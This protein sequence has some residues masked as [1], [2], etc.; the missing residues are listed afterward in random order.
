MLTGVKWDDYCR[1]VNLHCICAV[2]SG[3]RKWNKENSLYHRHVIGRERWL[4][5]WLLSSGWSNVSRGTTRRAPK[6]GRIIDDEGKVHNLSHPRWSD[7]RSNL[8]TAF[9]RFEPAAVTCYADLLVVLLKSQLV[10][11]FT[12]GQRWSDHSLF[13]L[14]MY[15]DYILFRGQYNR[16]LIWWLRGSL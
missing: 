1:V 11:L 5:N 2:E 10:R 16:G 12:S 6:D 8:Q 4:G 3:E 14:C 15:M 7:H 13:A 9:P